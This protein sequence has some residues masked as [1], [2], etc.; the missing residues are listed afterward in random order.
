MALGKRNVFNTKTRKKRILWQRVGYGAMSLTA[1]CLMYMAVFY[2]VRAPF[3][4]VK[5]IVVVGAETVSIDT[6]KQEAE[7]KLRGSYLGFI[8]HRFSFFIPKKSIE[9]GILTIPRVASAALSVEN[10]A[11]VITMKERSPDVLWCT[12]DTASSTCFYVANDGIAYEAAPS[13]SGTTLMRFVISSTS[14]TIGATLLSEHDRSL[15]IGIARIIETRHHFEVARIE[16]TADRD[17]ILYLARGGRLLL[18]TDGNLED[19]YSN[20]ASVL[21][22]EKYSMLTP[23]HFEYLDLR[24]GNKIFLEKQVPVATTTASTTSRVQ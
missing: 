18:S 9:Q 23:G 11:L 21:T 14:P 8:P 24:F 3:L 20:L 6:I 16:Y 15:L 5:D 17:A 22:S 4:L 12:D 10:N 7:D 13:L 19:T 2:T 1:V